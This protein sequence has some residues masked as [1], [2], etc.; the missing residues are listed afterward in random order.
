[1]ATST[2]EKTTTIRIKRTTKSE[3][4]K[5]GVWGETHDDIVQKL[6]F[7]YY[8]CRLSNEPLF[9]AYQEGEY[10]E[11]GEAMAELIKASRKR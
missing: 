8:L 2:R 10:N 9:K 4:E 1:M 5:L 11:A 6:L 7:T 3:L